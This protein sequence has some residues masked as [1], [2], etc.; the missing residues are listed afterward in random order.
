MTYLQ[1][2]LVFANMCSFL[3]YVSIVNVLSSFFKGITMEYITFK[4]TSLPIPFKIL[5]KRFEPGFPSKA[6]A[7]AFECDDNPNCMAHSFEE[8]FGCKLMS[9]TDGTIVLNQPVFQKVH[10]KIHYLFQ[11]F[12]FMIL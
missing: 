5:T 11:I 9:I 2:F 3:V 8:P 7:C 1:H 6:I 4:K 12:F 10:G